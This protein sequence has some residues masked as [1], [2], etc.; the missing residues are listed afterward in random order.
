MKRLTMLGAA[1][2][3]DVVFGSRFA[4]P[5]TCKDCRYFPRQS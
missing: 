3:S 5:V 1:L 4:S 2:G